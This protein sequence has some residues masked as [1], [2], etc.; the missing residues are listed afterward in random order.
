VADS[1]TGVTAVTSV[2]AETDCWGARARKAA[3][4]FL[5]EERDQ[6]TPDYGELVLSHLSGIFKEDYPNKTACRTADLLD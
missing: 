1:V 4:E 2:T 5:K 3:L 6:E